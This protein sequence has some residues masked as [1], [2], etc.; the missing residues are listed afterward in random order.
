VSF[1]FLLLFLFSVSIN[2]VARIC[3]GGLFFDVYNCAVPSR[4]ILFFDPS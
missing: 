4:L 3:E 1:F 2:I